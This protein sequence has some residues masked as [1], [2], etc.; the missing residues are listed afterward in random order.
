MYTLLGYHEIS[1]VEVINISDFRS[2]E[3]KVA[4]ATNNIA[5]TANGSGDGTQDKQHSTPSSNGDGTTTNVAV[6]GSSSSTANGAAT[7]ANSTGG[8][9]GVS[10]GWW[11]STKKGA[12]THASGTANGTA[13]TTESTGASS[14]WWG[15]TKKGADK[16]G[17]NKTRPGTPALKDGTM[18][19]E[20]PVLVIMQVGAWR[21][22]VRSN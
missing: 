2:W 10:S 3:A 21:L 12:D 9:T 22:R 14:G 17:G 1:M 19:L 16:A 18:D 11:G 5:T 8:S 7:Q 20:Q 4:T 6:N 13:S 15:S